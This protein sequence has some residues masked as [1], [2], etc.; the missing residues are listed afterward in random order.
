[1]PGP[2]HGV[3]PQLSSLIFPAHLA[4]CRVLSHMGACAHIHVHTHTHRAKGCKVQAGGS[5][6]SLL[7]AI[8]HWQCE[9]QASPGAA[10]AL[11][12]CNCPANSPSLPQP[13]LHADLDLNTIIHFSHKQLLR[14]AVTQG[15][16]FPALLWVAT[17][18]GS[19]A[20]EGRA[21]CYPLCQPL[22][23]SGDAR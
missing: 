2:P 22:G 15:Y 10:L 3:K 23:S 4:A 13:P 17:Q 5:S 8:V 6:C 7:S 19:A 14:V 11:C 20:W 1:M 9:L 12:R 21:S 18:R 16:F